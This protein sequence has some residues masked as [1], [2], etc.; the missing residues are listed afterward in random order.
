MIR[1][2]YNRPTPSA[3]HIDE[4]EALN[5]DVMRFMAILGICLMVIFALVQS[6]PSNSSQVIEEIAAKAYVDSMRALK[7]ESQQIQ[8]SVKLQEEELQHLYSQLDEFQVELVSL[9][10]ENKE[11]KDTKAQNNMSLQMQVDLNSKLENLQR[12]VNIAEAQLSGEEKKIADQT[13]Q[14]EN[15]KKEIHARE[16]H[17]QSLDAEINQ[18]K[19]KIDALSQKSH[20]QQTTIKDLKE[21]IKQEQLLAKSKPQQT[22]PTASKIVPPST[23]VIEKKGFTLR[24]ASDESLHTLIRQNTVK[25]FVQQGGAFW[26][27]NSA[28]NSLSFIKSS[29]PGKIYEM[30]SVTVPASYRSAF[31]NATGKTSSLQPTWG[32][33]LPTTLSQQVSGTMQNHKSGDF[34]IHQNGSLSV[35]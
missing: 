25:L 1:S 29:S 7:N 10:Q 8:S 16:T 26:Q 17:L 19:K 27:L 3:G 35:E 33:T 23:K 9:I 12:N 20:K 13:T 28:S 2:A 4:T 21:T 11:L 34:I 24:F 32:V 14:L 6:L 31:L 5:T 15:V 30:S 22:H 18:Q